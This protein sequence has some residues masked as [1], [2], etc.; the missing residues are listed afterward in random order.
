MLRSWLPSSIPALL[1]A[2]VVFAGSLFPSLVP[3][4]PLMQG[5]SSGILVGWRRVTASVSASP[6]SGA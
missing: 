3:R 4:P 2:L 1:V 5:V 6:R